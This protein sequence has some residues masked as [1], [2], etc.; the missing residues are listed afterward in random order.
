[1]GEGWSGVKRGSGGGGKGFLWAVRCWRWPRATEEGG[2]GVVVETWGGCALRGCGPLAG[3]RKG[4]GPPE[5]SWPVVARGGG[6]WTGGRGG[7]GAAHPGAG[8]ADGR[9]LRAVRVESRGTYIFNIIK[10]SEESCVWIAEADRRGTLPRDADK[11]ILLLR[12]SLH[13]LSL[14]LSLSLVCVCVCVCVCVIRTPLAL[15]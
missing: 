10:S 12:R 1:M 7:G 2:G 14:S 11:C 6:A 5:R 13:S 9:G 3:R 15:A 4:K 8:A